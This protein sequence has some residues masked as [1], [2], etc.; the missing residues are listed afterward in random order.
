MAFLVNGNPI[1]TDNRNLS[2]V[3]IATL[4]QDIN[5]GRLLYDANG[6]VGAADSILITKDSILQWAPPSAIGIASG[7]SPTPGST[8]FVTENGSDANDGESL[9][10]AWATIGY[11]LQNI[12]V[13][14]DDVLIIGA[15][16]YTESFPL[17]VPAGLTVKGAGQ[18]ATIIRPTAGT[19]TENGFLLNDDTTMEDFSIGD[20]FKPQGALN[21]SYAFS[22]APG[23]AITSRSPYLSRVSIINRGSN[24]TA[25]D[26]Y[27]YNSSDSYPVQAPGAGGINID[28]S[29]LSAAS[30]YGS[31]LLN[32]I[33]I[34]PVANKGVVMT[35]GARV[36]MLNSFIYFA[37]EAIVGESDL[38]AGIANSGRTR[39]TLDSPTST[40]SPGDTIEYY[41]TDGTTVLASGTVDSVSGNYTFL[42]DSGTGQF[43]VPRNRNA[44]SVNFVGDAE[45]STAQAKFG[46]TS[47]DVTATNADA[48]TAE[49]S[50]FG[51]GTGDFTVE[52]WFYFDTFTSN[53][54]ILD[55]RSTSDTDQ[56]LSIEELGSANIAVNIGTTQ[57]LSTTGS[58]LT[59]STWHHIAVTRSGTTMRVFIDGSQ[60]DS[61][62]NS[63]DLGTSGNLHL[64]ADYEDTNG[65]NGY[66]DDF[67]VEKG[68]AK[69]TGGFSV[70]TSALVGDKDTTILLNFDGSNG[71]KSTTDNIIVLQDIRFTGGNTADKL[72]L[73]DYQEFGAD[74]RSIGCAVEYGQKGVVGDGQGVSLRLFAINFNFVGTLGDY[75][76]DPNLVNQS[77]E[78]TETNGAEVSFVSIDQGGDFRVG[79]AFF[80]D[81]E[82]GQISFTNEVTDLTSLSSLTITDGTDSSVITPNSGRFGNVL[83]SGNQ[84]ESTTGDLNLVTAGAGDVNVQANLNVTGIISAS[85]VN[86]ASIQNG[87]T[88]IALDDTGSDGTIR[89]NTDGTEA[90]RFTS[91]NNLEVTGS[92]RTGAGNSITT[93]FYYGDGSNLTG[94]IGS[95]GDGNIAGNLTVE[96]LSVTGLSTFSDN[97]TANSGIFA[98]GD[99]IGDNATNITG[100]N[101]VTAV[102]F[103]GN[104]SNLTG[105]SSDAVD[106]TGT[107]QTFNSL[108]LTGPG[109]ALT[110]TNDVSIGG[111]LGANGIFASTVEV[112]TEI[113]PSSSGSGFV[114]KPSDRFGVVAANVG[115]FAVVVATNVS[116]SSSIT[117]AEFYGDGSNLTNIAAD[118]VDLTGT[119]QDLAGINVSGPG[120][121]LTV[122][123]SVSAGG[124]VTAADFYGDG[125]GL[126]NIQADNVDLTGTY[127]SLAGLELTGPGIALT[128]TND[129]SIGGSVFVGETIYA[130]EYD[131]LSDANLKENIL[132]L[133][134]ALDS[135]SGISGVSYTWKDSGK[136]TIGVIA[137]EVERVY[138]ELVN[139]GEHLTVNYNGLIGVLIEAVKELNEKV[140]DLQRQLDEK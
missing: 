62:T 78:V 13:S 105:I 81:Q 49:S 50:G 95:G 32:E 115:D 38:S 109:V 18:R 136:E 139:E 73:A 76:N 69:Y 137:Q 72:A 24:V 70:P 75:T 140:E 34:F 114:G 88:S 55:F 104:G 30:N 17:T 82:T 107:D 33:T 4:N 28:G 108:E 11:A 52:G 56:R 54:F 110:V 6:N 7:A 23:A 12:T 86:L 40:P 129:V 63:T 36:E 65:M 10:N 132:V 39:L 41:D 98:N 134:N 112:S 53:R 130:Q 89:F 45:L 116:A 118:N 57:I 15:G 122:A 64:G 91:D 2:E 26:P 93:G 19:E 8:Y 99:I 79:D 44:I 9:A 120:V 58:L 103:Y 83:I 48:V 101:S 119:Y 16:D 85:G 22:Y 59:P 77:A 131:S 60:A 87:D 126:T 51:F 102:D 74:L 61:A 27:G 25:S 92:I 43:V 14:G 71:D 121:A 84:I 68:V 125:S 80:V 5:I 135:L 97:I 67:R 29:V 20:M 47:L 66:I 35:N 46:P 42:T 113:V 111:T 100:I 31:F 90:G 21:N 106:L 124:S 117:A 123:N 94:L 3:G 1:V 37:E 138:P 96:S 128:I 127:Q 133:E